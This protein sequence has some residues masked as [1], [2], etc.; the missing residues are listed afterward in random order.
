MW[1]RSSVST[2]NLGEVAYLAPCDVA[3]VYLVWE[4]CNIHYGSERLATCTYLTMRAE[5]KRRERERLRDMA[6]KLVMRARGDVLSVVCLI[7]KQLLTRFVW[8]VETSFATPNERAAWQRSAPKNM[9]FSQ[10]VQR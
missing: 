10:S 8:T 4:M 1:E 6:D 7:C 3:T 5:R 2:P 9:A